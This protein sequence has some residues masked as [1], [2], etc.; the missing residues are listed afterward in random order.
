MG[1][2]SSR[3]F[4]VTLFPLLITDLNVHSGYPK[5]AKTNWNQ[6]IYTTVLWTFMIFVGYIYIYMAVYHVQSLN[7]LRKSW[8]VAPAQGVA[9]DK[10]WK[11]TISLVKLGIPSAKSHKIIHLVFPMFFPTCQVR[12]SRFYSFAR[13]DCGHHWTRAR[14]QAPELGTDPLE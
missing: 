7:L 2:G 11:D 9:Y 12:V 6:S 8:I 4:C 1:A 10:C 13:R 3:S 5:H 14:S